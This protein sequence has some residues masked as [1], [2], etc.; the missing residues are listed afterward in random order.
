MR[1]GGKAEFQSGDVDMR[2]QV[3]DE[4]RIMLLVDSAKVAFEDI[5]VSVSKASL[6]WLYNAI[7]KVFHKA[8]VDQITTLINM[9]LKNDVP[10][11]INAYLADL[12]ST[13]RRTS[14]A[15]IFA[16]HKGMNIRA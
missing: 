14:R 5:T 9:S 11:T 3:A 12:P 16:Q 2:F 4:G 8:L 13:V 1:A 15:V 6:D 10:K 7:L